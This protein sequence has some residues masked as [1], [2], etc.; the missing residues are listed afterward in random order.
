MNKKKHFSGSLS[1]WR[2]IAVLVIS[3]SLYIPNASAEP[4]QWKIEDGGNGHWYDVV[5]LVGNW[6]NANIHSQNQYWKG[7]QGHLATLTSKKENDFVWTQFPWNEYFLGGYQTDKT[8]EPGGNW[9][10]VTG[11]T[12]AF[13]NWFH[14]GSWE[15]NNHNGDED[16]L[17]FWCGD[18]WNDTSNSWVAGGYIIEYEP[19]P[20]Q[21]PDDTIPP[22]GAI[23]A[24]PNTIWPPNGKNVI[25]KVEGYLFDELSV[26]RDGDGIG[27]SS[28][29]LLIDGS[30]VVLR[31]ATTDLLDNEGY[32]SVDIEVVAEKEATYLVE[33]YGT[34]TNP[35]E[36]NSGLVDAT[37]IHVDK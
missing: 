14:N 37:V 24:Y 13:T 25:V 6:Q 33:L 12:W 34:D 20:T 17:Q 3:L 5:H 9:V 7:A 21:F 31:D 32:F 29:Y 16:F 8:L 11:E 30:E 27:I 19:I 28:A 36:P 22:A 26:Y 10:W 35:G 15:P 1:F 23:H 4:I 18:T 2:L